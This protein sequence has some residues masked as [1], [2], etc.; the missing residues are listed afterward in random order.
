MKERVQLSILIFIFALSFAILLITPTFL[1][2]QSSIFLLLRVG[3]VL[4]LITPII[5]IPI[6]WM[7]FQVKTSSYPARK[8]MIIFLIFTAFW[9]QGQGMRLSANAISH[10]LENTKMT[11]VYMLTYFFDEI[12]SHYI[13]QI[14]I[15]GLTI[16][17]LFRQWHYPFKEQ[18]GIFLEVI[19]GIIYG[20]TYFIIVVEGQT[21]TL[22]IPF[23]LLLCLYG[24]FYGR[25]RLKQQPIFTL[26]FIGHFIALI[27]FAVWAF[28]WGGLPQFSEFGII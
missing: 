11:D 8:E 15:I 1:T 3:E 20:I 12:L 14:G 19:A 21:A 23:T 10:L 9:A 28:Y 6:Y 7:L 4:D 16:L 27:L 17:L 26:F 2:K 24:I 5:L 13:W 25:G 18:S 22:A